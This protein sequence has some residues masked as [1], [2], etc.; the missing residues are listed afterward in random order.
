MTGTRLLANKIKKKIL[1]FRIEI[2]RTTNITIR[3]T[4]SYNELNTNQKAL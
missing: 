1:S 4:K 2:V 3:I